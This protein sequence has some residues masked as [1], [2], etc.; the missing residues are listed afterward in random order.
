MNREPGR[1]P[2]EI[3]ELKNPSRSLLILRN[4]EGS[5]SHDRCHQHDLQK[6][7]DPRMSSTNVA[8]DLISCNF[9]AVL[10]RAPSRVRHG[11][12]SDRRQ[13]TGSA[14]TMKTLLLL[15][16]AKSSWK[17][18]ALDDHERPLNKRGRRDAPR[19]GELVRERGLMPDIVIC[20]DAVRARLTAEAMADAAR[21]AGKILLDP[22]LYL[23]GPD[24]ILSLLRRV[25]Q[26]AKT[27]MIVGHNPGL[28]ELI[29]QQTGEPHDLPTAGLAQIVL[30]IDRW[31]DLT[32]STRGTLMGHW[33]PKQLP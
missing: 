32:L 5:G 1:G 28:E 3:K 15:R 29:E 20:S 17:E 30:P 22:H 10:G 24:E 25:R 31:R 9:P 6:K 14:N 12:E 26:N 7:N 23:A 21:Y 19:M 27:L 16:H 13:L 8:H 18:P 4:R 2:F 33:R 11:F